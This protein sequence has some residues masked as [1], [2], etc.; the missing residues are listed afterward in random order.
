[1]TNLQQLRP[2]A[3]IVGFVLVFPLLTAGTIP[4]QLRSGTA[5]L[6]FFTLIVGIFLFY[7][8]RTTAGVSKATFLVSGAMLGIVPTVFFFFASL[9]AG[10]PQIPILM[11][12]VGSIAGGVGGLA[13]RNLEPFTLP[14]E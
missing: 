1:M 9:I 10:R 11:L 4:A 7:G 6:F 8:L 3:G 12:L 14:K 2:I 13:V 5:P